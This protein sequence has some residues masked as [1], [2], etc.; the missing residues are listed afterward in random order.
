MC[1][2]MPSHPAR[3]VDPRWRS[4]RGEALASARLGTALEGA[5]PAQAAFPFPL[6]VTAEALSADG[7]ALAAAVT[8]GSLALSAAGVQQSR[9]VAGAPPA[10]CDALPACQGSQTSAAKSQGQHHP[11]HSN[12]LH[13]DVKPA[14]KRTRAHV[15][16]C[17]LPA[18]HL[19]LFGNLCNSGVQQLI[20]ATGAG[21]CSKSKAGM[22]RRDKCTTCAALKQRPRRGANHS[23]LAG[24]LMVTTNAFSESPVAA[25]ARRWQCWW[26]TRRAGRAAA[27]AGPATPAA[28]RGCSRWGAGNCSPTPVHSRRWQPARR[29][30]A[31]CFLVGTKPTFKKAQGRRWR[32]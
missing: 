13:L 28:R 31:V 30:G 3:Q 16:A 14:L 25:Q 10:M 27:R 2:L 32:P 12:L 18:F 17:S 20:A 7:G 21:R 11:S 19:T 15:A 4:M 6:R 8:A 22:S 5:L 1:G 23:N 24:V 26:R 29:H 9:R